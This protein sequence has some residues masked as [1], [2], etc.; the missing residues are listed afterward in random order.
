MKILGVA[1]LFTQKL[2]ML[3]VRMRRTFIVQHIDITSCVVRLLFATTVTAAKLALQANNVTQEP[4]FINCNFKN[5]NPTAKME[6]KPA[7]KQTDRC[8]EGNHNIALSWCCFC[9]IKGNH[10]VTP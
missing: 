3:N 6:L 1:T 7:Y 8:W 2:R 4:F 5:Q 10:S 9:H